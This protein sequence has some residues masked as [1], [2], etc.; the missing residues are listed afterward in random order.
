MNYFITITQRKNRKQLKDKN[1]RKCDKQSWLNHLIMRVCI[2]E[3]NTF[4]SLN[5]RIAKTVIQRSQVVKMQV[6]NYFIIQTI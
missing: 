6:P 3:G 4:S 5:K 2:T 1:T